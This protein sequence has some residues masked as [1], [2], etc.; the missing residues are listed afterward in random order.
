[1]RSPLEDD[2]PSGRLLRSTPTS[3]ATLTPPCSTVSPRTKD[4]GMPSRIE[5]NTIASAEP[6]ACDPSESLRSPPPP[7]V[8]PPVADG[9]GRRAHQRKQA[10]E[11]RRQLSL[12]AS[13]TNSNET[14]PMQQASAQGHHHRD[15]RSDSASCLVRHQRADE[16][17]RGS[18]STPSE[19]LEHLCEP[20]DLVPR[21]QQQTCPRYRTR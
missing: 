19:R 1:M 20:N 15:E 13:S 14:D 9:E 5:P 18:Q 6:D 3:K 2:I 7:S 8:E 10:H 4:S 12:M 17:R 11:S 16:E 21:V